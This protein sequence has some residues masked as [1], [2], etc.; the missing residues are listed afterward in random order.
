MPTAKQGVYTVAGNRGAAGSKAQS[1]NTATACCC[2]ACTGL[3]CLDRTRFF[4][5][6]LLSE[7]DLNNEQ[8][9]WLAKNRLHNRYLNGWGVVCGMQV[10]CGECDGW[11][12]VQSGYAIDPCGNDIIVC[13]PQ[14]FNVLQAIQACCAPAQQQAANCSPLR[15]NPSPTCK[16]ST[17]EWCITIQY[18]EQAS[19]LVTPLS[20]SGSQTASTCNCGTNGNGSSTS[21]SSSSTGG[22]C[23]SSS[24]AMTTSATV[25]AGAC[26]ATRIVEGFQLGVVPGA[27]VAAALEAGNPNSLKSQVELCTL[28]LA[29]LLEQAPDLSQTTNA[30][31]A[32][33]SACNYLA[34]VTKVLTNATN[35]TLCAIL[36][37]LAFIQVPAGK[38]VG[39]YTGVIASIKKLLVQAYRNCICYTLIPPCPPQPCDNRIVLA[40]LTIQNGEIIQICHFPGRKQL[41]TLQT[42]GY[43]LGPLGLDN[44]GTGLSEIFE[45]ACCSTAKER[46]PDPVLGNATYYNAMMTTAGVTSGAAMNRIATHYVSQNLGAAVVN[47]IY[48]GARAVD[49]RPMINLQTETVSRSLKDQGFT[50]VTLVPVDDDAAWDAEAVTSGAQYAPAAVSVDQSLTVYTQGKMVVGFDVVDPTTAKIQDLQKQITALQS[51]LNQPQN[52]QPPENKAS[53]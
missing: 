6:Q 47:A 4:A 42:L 18:Q 5:G 52:Q 32:Y 38:E 41:I 45:L 36:D 19:R 26:E 31:S 24:T 43:W 15:Y 13:A 51:Q 17:Q 14:N 7:A 28:G 23:K 8:S 39:Y 25:P 48:P 46:Q 16:D 10:V 50:R 29:A 35:I 11:V 21:S 22:S 49:L 40:C 34:L 2:A 53:S 37:D 27:E 30:Q 3:Q 44:L 20:N 33:L 1:A 12:T 9:Y